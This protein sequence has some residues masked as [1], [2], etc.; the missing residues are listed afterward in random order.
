[1]KSTLITLMLAGMAALTLFGCGRGESGYTPQPAAAV[2]EASVAPGSEAKLFPLTVGNRWTF[3]QTVA[4]QA[5]TGQAAAEDREVTFQVK[6]VTPVDG[7][8]AAEVE[9]IDENGVIVDVTNWR[10][11]S[12]G[13]YQ[14]AAGTGDNRGSFDPPQPI[15]RFP[16]EQGN[17]FEYSGRGPRPAG[18]AGN[19]TS[20]GTVLG[21]QP[22]DTAMGPISA[23]AVEIRS[24]FM[25][26]D[27][28]GQMVEVQSESTTWWAPDV[29]LV[30]ITQVIVGPGG[31]QLSLFRLKD[32]TLQ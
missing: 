14:T 6:S 17:S 11:T 23:I 18:G 12:E 13:I 27:D 30:R 4:A 24:T 15:V 1:M 26:P 19:F 3:E 31:R 22:V 8:T 25:V 32:Y 7:G 2:E 10:V 16:I 21:P 29:G 5:A 9:I 20:R 28:N